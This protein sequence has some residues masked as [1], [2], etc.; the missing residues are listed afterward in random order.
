[1]KT[2]SEVEVAE[3]VQL[4]Q[5]SSAHLSHVRSYYRDPALVMYLTR[6][7]SKAG[8]AIYG[9][10]PRTLRALGRFFS[11]SYPA[12]TWHA[13]R[14]L[15]VSAA[16]LLV[17]ALLGGAWIADSPAARDAAI[18][19]AAREA[20]LYKDFEEYYESERASQFASEVFTNNIGVGIV[21]FASGIAFCIPTAWLLITNG[22]NIGFAGG[23]FAS[24]GELGKFFGLILPHGLLELTAVIIA[25]GAGLALGWALVSPGDRR[26]RRALVD[27]GRGIVVIVLGLVPTFVVA[28][29]IEGFVTGQ[30]WPTW[31]RVGIGAIVELA[32]VIYIVML[33]RDAER[34]GFTGAIGE[35]DDS[36]WAVSR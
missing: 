13:R 12:A 8:A 21:A 14:F 10:K 30:P 4:Y 29:L 25:G 32:F 16:L 31:L 27:E 19:P 20:Y 2:M 9:S 11:V 33:G 26:R 7:V 3:L 34:K 35:H 17:P 24:G 5:R 1:M 6:V 23:L 15:A 28:G 22:A 18:P 36:G